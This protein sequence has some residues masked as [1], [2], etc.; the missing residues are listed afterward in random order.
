MSDVQES[1]WYSEEAATLG[2]RIAGAR[3]AAGLGQKELARRLGV[4]NETLAKWEEDRSEPRANRIQMLAGVLGVS[5][6][7][8]LTGRGEGPDGPADAPLDEGI[9]ELLDE[10]RQLQTQI[11]RAAARLGQAEKAL[12]RR[13]RESA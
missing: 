2:D 3:E 12:R 9:A 5:L 4:N 1:D 11:T 6:S 8:L 10:V 13:L 7:W